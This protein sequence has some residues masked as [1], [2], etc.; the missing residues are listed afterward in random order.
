MASLDAIIHSQSSL[1][2][3]VFFLN[4]DWSPLSDGHIENRTVWIVSRLWVTVVIN[5][6]DSYRLIKYYLY[7]DLNE[8]WMHFSSR[9]V[10]MRWTGERI[11]YS[12]NQTENDRDR[13]KINEFLSKYRAVMISTVCNYSALRS[14]GFNCTKNSPQT[15]TH[16]STDR[17]KPTIEIHV[18]R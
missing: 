2:K 13:R 16:T 11:E 6:V 4:V 8:R 10:V 17:Y 15:H 7:D 9:R 1:K 14:I 18:S 5:I 3:P 12:R